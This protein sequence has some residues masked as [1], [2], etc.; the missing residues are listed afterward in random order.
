[1][2]ENRVELNESAF[3]KMEQDLIRYREALEKLSKG[4]RAPGVLKIAREALST[5][6]VEAQPDVI[7]SSDLM[8]LALAE[9]QALPD[10]EKRNLADRKPEHGWL[11]GFCVGYRKAKQATVVPDEGAPRG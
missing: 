4:N 5:S 11:N 10:F 6:T 3:L 9:L 7:H 1:M 2:S 8:D